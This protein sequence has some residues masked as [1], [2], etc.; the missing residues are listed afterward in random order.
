MKLSRV[1][2]TIAGLLFGGYVCG[3]VP[4]IANKNKMGKLENY[5]TESKAEMASLLW[6]NEIIDL[7]QAKKNLVRNGGKLRRVVVAVIDTGVDKSH[8]NL[9]DSLWVNSG[10]TGF[11]GNHRRKESNGIDDDKNGFVDDVNGWSFAKNNSDLTDNHGHGTHIA[12]IIGA[13]SG[14]GFEGIAPT[15]ELMIIKYYDPNHSASGSIESILGSFEYAL[16]MGADI[17]NFSGGGLAPCAEE[18]T[19]L[20]LAEQKGILVVAAAGNEHSNSDREPFY[21]ADYGL[22]NIIS[23]TALAKNSRL[24]AS[25]NYGM[26]SVDLAAPGQEIISTLPGSSFGAMS[27]TSQATAYVSGV[28]ALLVGQSRGK[29]SIESLRRQLSFTVVKDKFLASR[30]KSRGSLNAFRALTMKDESIN[31]VGIVV[32]KQVGKEG[33]PKLST[34]VFGVSKDSSN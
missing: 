16:R 19:L 7:R 20:K 30:T 22:A 28:A 10:E 15:A 17:I 12:G 24:L 32:N 5:S 4:M 26:N 13:R 29:L 21:P 11:D 34:E 3:A 2:A 14:G 9:R 18:K 1:A 23:V 6:S 33:G 8:P 25:A 31:A 27:G